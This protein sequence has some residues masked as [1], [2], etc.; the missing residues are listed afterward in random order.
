MTNEIL[1]PVI[2]NINF[3]LIILLEYYFH[4]ITAKV[5]N[6][7]M[8]KYQ[9]LHRTYLNFMPKSSTKERGLISKIS[10]YKNNSILVLER[11]CYTHLVCVHTYTS[12]L[13]VN[14]ITNNS[15]MTLEI[16]ISKY[17]IKKL[18]KILLVLKS[19]SGHNNQTLNGLTFS[20]FISLSDNC[21]SSDMLSFKKNN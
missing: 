19:E 8:Q 14:V 9:M 6:K 2:T 17:G 7:W 10:S 3:Y 1:Y 11:T 20:T 4:L 12:I 13:I 18:W 21:K 16:R 5:L 15:W